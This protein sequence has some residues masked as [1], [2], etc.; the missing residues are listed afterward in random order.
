M[1]QVKWKV[2]FLTGLMVKR[3][4]KSRNWVFWNLHKFEKAKVK[5]SKADTN[6]WSNFFHA[7]NHPLHSKPSLCEDTTTH[8]ALDTR[9]CLLSL[10]FTPRNDLDVRFGEPSS[11][12]MYLPKPPIFLL[13]QDSNDVVLWEV[14]V[15]LFLCC[16]RTKGLSFQ[17]FYSLPLGQKAT[18]S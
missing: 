10:Y 9:R 4:Q 3:K 14:Q 7:G 11:S 15:V 13:L 2:I 1:L 5:D 17:V 18:K 16:P 8:T 6:T 12:S